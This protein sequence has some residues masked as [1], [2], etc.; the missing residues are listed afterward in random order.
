[1]HVHVYGNS[2]TCIRCYIATQLAISKVTLKLMM[3]A[4]NNALNA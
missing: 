1:M 4:C 3:T 2:A